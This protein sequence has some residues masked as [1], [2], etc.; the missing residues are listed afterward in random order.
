MPGGWMD[1]PTNSSKIIDAANYAFK[2]VNKVSNSLY[3]YK[4]MNIIEAK[5]Q[6]VAGVKYQ[7]TFDMGATKCRRNGDN[8]H[9]TD[10]A[11]ASCELDNSLVSYSPSVGLH[12]FSI[13]SN[14]AIFSSSTSTAASST[15]GRDHG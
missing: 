2:H 13:N 15:S 12:Y 11:L 1:H 10:E 9:L 5:S 7:I 8:S 3:Y 4:M 14:L 6:V